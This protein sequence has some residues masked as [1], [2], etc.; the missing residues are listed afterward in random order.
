LNHPP[1]ARC[2]PCRRHHT[3]KGR[4]ARRTTS[5]TSE[6]RPLTGIRRLRCLSCL[7]SSP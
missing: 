4:N 7:R 3:S 5:S 2:V 6:S 1:H